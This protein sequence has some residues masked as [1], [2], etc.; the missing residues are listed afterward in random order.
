MEVDLRNS[1]GWDKTTKSIYTVVFAVA[2]AVAG[3][4][5]GADRFSMTES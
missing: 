5:A 2:V 3:V 4:G 1:L